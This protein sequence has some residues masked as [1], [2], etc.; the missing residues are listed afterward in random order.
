MP[1]TRER[2][3]ETGT[4]SLGANTV[5]FMLFFGLA[6]LESIVSRRWWTAIF[7]IVVLFLFLAMTRRP[8]R[9]QD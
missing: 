9:R 2:R 4:P 5:V 6:L 1:E 8:A 7:W 3:S